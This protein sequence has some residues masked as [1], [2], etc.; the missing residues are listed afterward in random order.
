LHEEHLVTQEPSQGESPRR[1]TPEDIQFLLNAAEAICRGRN[2]TTYEI[3]VISAAWAY[4]LHRDLAERKGPFY[5][6]ICGVEY[7]KN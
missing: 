6:L 7:R 3:S 2:L 5:Q 4:L 1:A